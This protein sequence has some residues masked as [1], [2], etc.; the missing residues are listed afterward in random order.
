M[1]TLTIMPKS[2]LLPALVGHLRSVGGGAL[3]ETMAAFASGVDLIAAT[4]KSYA[5]GDPIP[6]SSAQIKHPSGGYAAGVK[7]AQESPFEYRVYNDSKIAG[8]IENGAPSYDMKTTHPYGPKSRMANKGTK[9]KPR[10]V[11][12]VIIPMRW[13]TP[14][15]TGHFRNIIPEQVYKMV[16]AGIRAGEFQRTRATGQTH[17]EPN[18]WGQQVE[19]AE[20]EGEHGRPLWGSSLKAPG[21]NIDGL[22]A[23]VG[24][25]NG[26]R[27][28][29]YMTFRVI[30]AESPAGMWI[31]PARPALRITEHVVRNTIEMVQELVDTGFRKDISGGQA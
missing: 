26:V 14:G 1:T 15:S 28:T 21:Q 23:M 20:Y 31:Q 17:L 27:N 3:P 2:D 18:W 13:G 8:V 16:L 4:W 22:S 19:R 7:I 10:W 6:G 24:D 9:K 11:P 12:Y 25:S 5:M 30:S 29:N